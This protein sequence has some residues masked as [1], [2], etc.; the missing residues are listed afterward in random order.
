MRPPVVVTTAVCIRSSRPGSLQI[1]LGWLN[2]SAPQRS[3][4][5]KSLDGW[6]AGIN[7][8]AAV[9]GQP[10]TPAQR[11]VWALVRKGMKRLTPEGIA[12]VKGAITRDL[13]D[14]MLEWGRRKRNNREDNIPKELRDGFLLQHAA[15][16]RTSELE[17]IRSS[18]IT[19]DEKRNCYLIVFKKQKDPLAGSRSAVLV[20]EHD[21]DSTRNAAIH[22]LLKSAH[23]RGD[24]EMDE[25]KGPG[26]CEGTSMGLRLVLV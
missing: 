17:L 26:G 8:F 1:W 6:G 25:S 12:K 3:F 2:T 14:E 9:L 18:N 24:D 13:V 20:E 21:T 19:F 10:P 22:D 4:A 23:E 15:G 16:V 7:L 5:H 11:E